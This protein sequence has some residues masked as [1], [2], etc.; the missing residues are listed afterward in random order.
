MTEG[1][2]EAIV[3]RKRRRQR[4]I[5]RR[6]RTVGSQLVRQQ[7]SPAGGPPEE[8]AVVAEIPDAAAADALYDE[9]LRQVSA[10]VAQ[11]YS[12]GDTEP[13]RVAL[14]GYASQERHRVP[15]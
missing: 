11:T 1:P 15:T 9:T 5:V 12:G 6:F 7:F 13:H 8:V 3:G 2:V 4:R 14:F 10:M